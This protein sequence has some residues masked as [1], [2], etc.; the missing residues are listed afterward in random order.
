MLR[1]ATTMTD[2]KTLY[3]V[4]LELGLEHHLV[5]KGAQEAAISI[6]SLVKD[7]ASLDPP[8]QQDQV[9]SQ[10]LPL[11]DQATQQV[12]HPQLEVSQLVHSQMKYHQALLG[13]T[14][15]VVVKDTLQVDLE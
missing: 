6:R 14:L 15:V 1:M 12:D 9:D 11:R 7:Q 3:P 2:P 8:L 10:G 5:L 13:D 4:V